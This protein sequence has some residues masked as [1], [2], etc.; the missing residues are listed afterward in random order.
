MTS[1]RR[2]QLITTY[3]IGS[4]ITNKDNETFMVLAPDTWVY[5][6]RPKYLVHEP[7]LLRYLG[8]SELI[9]PPE[10]TENGKTKQVE[11]FTTTIR[12]PSWHFCRRCKTLQRTRFEERLGRCQKADCKGW[13]TD[14]IPTRFLSVC[15]EG[16]IEDFP[17]ME[18]VHNGQCPHDHELEYQERASLTGLG[19]IV[20]HCRTCGNKRSLQGALSP[21]SLR[22]IKGCSGH[23]PWL[24]NG[25]SRSTLQPC[26]RSL[27][28][29]QKAASNVYFP[30]LRNSIFIPERSDLPA[31]IKAF[32]NNTHYV[33]TIKQVLHKEDT[34]LMVLKSLGSFNE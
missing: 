4:M 17:F 28:G 8:V 14:L 24:Y 2:G 18:W 30:V 9:R 1:I 29:V 33:S 23:Q 3:G 21:D 13:W 15:E 20:I 10:P 16:H 32:L 25:G 11:E 5:K 6:N 26:D 7:N 31:N 19:G 12:F 27:L 22:N 34:C